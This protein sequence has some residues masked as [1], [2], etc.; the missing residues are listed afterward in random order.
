M[1]PE[2]EKTHQR[3]RGPRKTNSNNINSH[4]TDKMRFPSKAE[5]VTRQLNYENKRDQSFNNNNEFIKSEKRFLPEIGNARQN[6]YLKSRGNSMTEKKSNQ[7]HSK[8][9]FDRNYE[10]EERKDAPTKSRKHNSSVEPPEAIK[11]FNAGILN[12]DVTNLQTNL[13]AQVVDHPEDSHDIT[14]DYNQVKKIPVHI[15]S[16]RK[17]IRY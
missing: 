13:K 15:E 8:S 17:K 3:Q 2:W 14:I 6:E 9:P 12:N 11:Y 4:V 16:Q 10:A 7:R 1:L 5:T